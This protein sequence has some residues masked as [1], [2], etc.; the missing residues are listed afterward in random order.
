MKSALLIKKSPAYDIVIIVAGLFNFTLFLMQQVIL[1][2]S[3]AANFLIGF[4]VLS[5][6][7]GS[8]INRSFFVFTAGITIWILGFILL[9]KT[10]IFLFDKFIHY[11]GLFMV[12]GLFLFTHV[13]P[14][15]SLPR[16]FWLLCIPL[17]IAALFVIP[18]NLLIEK[19]IVHND[20]TL[21]PVNGPALPFYIALT[22]VYIVW[23]LIALVFSF[24]RSKGQSRIQIKYFFAGVAVFIIAA[25]IF[26]GLLP[27]LGIFQ[28]NYFGPFF[29]VILVGLTAYAIIRHEL[30]DIRIV[31]QR[32]LVY[33][34]LL[35]VISGF[36]IGA[37]Q[38]LGYILNQITNISIILS[39]GLTMVLGIFFWKPL[40]VYFRKVTD[41]IFF[42][43]NYNYAEALHK[44]SRILNT[45]L[46]LVE[47]IGS[48]S[49]ALKEIF[50]TE[51]VK[52][53]LIDSPEKEALP[54]DHEKH[55]VSVPII[56][57]D[58]SIGTLDLGPKRSGGAY[59]GSDIRLLQT[60]AY[61]AAVAIEKGKLYEKVQK[62]SSHL[63]NLVEKRTIEIRK[64][65]EEQKR[66]MIDISHNLQTPLMVIRTDLEFLSDM[67]FCRDNALVAQKSIE[68][69]SNFIRQL[70]R[71]ARLDQSAYDDDFQKINLSELVLSQ[72][73]YFEVMI[74]EVGGKFECNVPSQAFIMG[75]RQLL[76]EMIGNLVSNAMKY[77]R[78]NVRAEISIGL[79]NEEHKAILV[80]KDN[81]IGILPEDLPKIFSRFYRCSDDSSN[82]GTGLGLAIVEKI[83]RKH[84]GDV[85]V[86]SS[87]GQGSEFRISLPII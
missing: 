20:G 82:K 83:T 48:S 87:P 13:F 55:A 52:F 26:S 49:E 51:T 54:E 42:K 59:D 70:L 67:P 68:R 38:L 53:S 32:G 50:R 47:I 11:G 75:H 1:M 16:R 39:A 72:K 40:E 64:I 9:F 34:V 84:L 19:M 61:Q 44:L 77:R 80:V 56:F 33:M 14:D 27:S 86:T 28:L 15:T 57:E 35:A 3:A 23:S 60:F 74:N 46:M 76:E 66:A 43:D 85:S 10:Q 18:F 37:L 41:H 4:Y 31:I 45:K 22:G 58:Q 25:L 29:S 2:F 65:Q 36:Y 24:R 12:F 79:K 62:Y 69:I 30:L 8:I 71:L 21:E 6:R 78:P 5:R 81:G 17:V 73:E 63:E 7:P